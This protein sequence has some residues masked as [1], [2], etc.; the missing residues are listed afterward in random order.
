MVLLSRVLAPCRLVSGL[1]HYAGTY[2]LN[3][4]GISAKRW[5]LPKSLHG[6]KTQ[7]N[8]TILSGV[9][10][11]NLISRR[12]ITVYTAAPCLTLT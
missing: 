10:T 9:K 5:H 12:S 11:C 2:Y 8:T 6:D 7:N 1:P 4:Q 3:L